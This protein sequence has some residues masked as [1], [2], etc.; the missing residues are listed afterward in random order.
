MAVYISCMKQ[1]LQ[2]IP[3]WFCLSSIGHYINILP[4]TPVATPGGPGRPSG[5]AGPGNEGPGIPVCP[6]TPVAPVT[7][8]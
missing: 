5:P 3:H 2:Q 8:E 1:V 6:A 7:A 4:T